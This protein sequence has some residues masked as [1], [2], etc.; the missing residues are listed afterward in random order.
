[1]ANPFADDIEDWE[2]EA[3]DKYWDV[4]MESAV[5]PGAVTGAQRDPPVRAKAQGPAKTAPLTVT[6][7]LQKR[8]PD[9]SDFLGLRAPKGQEYR[10]PSGLQDFTRALRDQ[11]GLKPDVSDEKLWKALVNHQVEDSG[12]FVNL[13]GRAKKGRDYEPGWLEEVDPRTNVSNWYKVFWYAPRATGVPPAVRDHLRKVTS[14]PVNRVDKPEGRSAPSKLTSGDRSWTP[15]GATLT[16]EE[17]VKAKIKDTQNARRAKVD[18]MLYKRK[19]VPTQPPPDKRAMS[20]P[21]VKP[22]CTDEEPGN[23]LFKRSVSED[24]CLPIIPECAE[25]T[26]IQQ[27]TQAVVR[28]SGAPL[29]ANAMDSVGIVMGDTQTSNGTVIKTGVGTIGC[30]HNSL[31]TAYHVIDLVYINP[32]VGSKIYITVRGAS[33]KMWPTQKGEG[34]VSL[35]TIRRIDIQR[36][37]CVLTRGQFTVPGLKATCDTHTDEVRLLAFFPSVGDLAVNTGRLPMHISGSDLHSVITQAGCSGG[38]LMVMTKEGHWLVIGIHVG[39]RGAAGAFVRFTQEDIKFLQ[40]SGTDP[41]HEY[42]AAP[43]DPSFVG[44]EG[45]VHPN[46]VGGC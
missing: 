9:L 26:V 14:P 4:H 20:V 2:Q 41:Q 45:A 6:E 44:P 38:V 7:R 3:F 42:V 5:P 13:F 43:D 37:I 40:G 31:V 1:M 8:L 34:G 15:A 21:Q 17:A 11:I 16:A 18:G 29:P 12:D 28:E 24:E 36:D 35:V 23:L 25:V 22:Q 19:W 10:G 27:G 39:R 32:T 30:V 46:G 33:N